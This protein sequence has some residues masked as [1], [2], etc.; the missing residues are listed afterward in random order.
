MGFFPRMVHAP[1][2]LRPARGGGQPG[3][4]QGQGGRTE[5]QVG[6]LQRLQSR[7]CLEY[8]DDPRPAESPKS[9]NEEDPSSMTKYHDEDDSD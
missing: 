5:D 9:G 2:G 3:L 8:Q 7:S 4:G 6:S 1:C